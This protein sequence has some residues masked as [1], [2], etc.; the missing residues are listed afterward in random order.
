MGLRRPTR[1][2]LDSIGLLQYTQKPKNQVGIFFVHKSDGQRIRLIV[3][4]RSTNAL[5]RDPPGVDL[6]SSEGFSRIECELSSDAR[7]GSQKFVD[8]LQT[9]NIFVGLSDVKD[10][11]AFTDCGSPGG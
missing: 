2:Q 5:F 8:E 1:K 10:C 4:A 3:D 9:M 11:K 6:C 7:P